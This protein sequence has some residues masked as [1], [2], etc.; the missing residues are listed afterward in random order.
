MNLNRK[1]LA[2]VLLAFAG[3]ARAQTS[4][5]VTGTITASGCVEIDVTGKGVVGISITNSASGS[6]W[7]GTIQPEVAIGGDAPQNTTVTP[8][9]ST[10][11]Q[12][13]ITSNNTYQSF[14][15]SATLFRLCGNTVT[16][17]AVVKLTAS[18]LAARFG[19]G[20]GGGG[21]N[22]P[23]GS[24]GQ[25]QTNAG[26]VFG[27]FTPSGDCTINTTSGV[28]TCTKTNDTAFGTFATQNY[29]TPPTIG[30]TTPAAGF[31]TTGSFTGNLT[32]NMT[33]GPFCV[34]E[35]SGVLSATGADCGSGGG[36][37]GLSG[38]TTGQVPI[39]AT[40]STV[41][42]SKA[43]QGTDT[44]LLSSGTI[45]GTGSNLCTDANGGATTSGCPNGAVT[46]VS[47][48]DTSLTISPTTG[49]IIASINPSFVLPLTNLN[50]SSAGAGQVPCVGSGG[51][52][53]T[54]LAPSIGNFLY[55][56]NSGNCAFSP[57]LSDNGTTLTYTPSGGITASKFTL[58]G[59][60]Y[61]TTVPI[62]GSGTPAAT[63]SGNSGMAVSGDGNFYD[64]VA[65]AGWGQIAAIPGA[66]SGTT[67]AIAANQIIVGSTAGVFKTVTLP[68]CSTSLTWN[69]TSVTA[70]C[71]STTSVQFGNG[72]STAG[73]NGTVSIPSAF[74]NQWTWSGQTGSSYSQ[75]PLALLFPVNNATSPYAAS[76]EGSTSALAWTAPIKQIS[77][78]GWVALNTTYGTN[79]NAGY[80]D[81]EKCESNSTSIFTAGVPDSG[82]N[83]VDGVVLTSGSVF[84]AS[85]TGHVSADQINTAAV[86]ASTGLLGS[87]SSRQL[88]ATTASQVAT[89]VQGLTGCNTA[90][91]VFTPQ[92]SDC[93]A[94]SGGGSLSS[95]TAASASNTL[96]N[97]NNP[98][99]WNWAQ[100]TNSQSAFT[101]GETTAATG[102]GDI[103][104]NVQTLAS[105]TAL[106][107]QITSRGT[108]NG[109]Q[110]TTGGL[111]QAIGSGGI[112]ATECN[113]GTC[114]S[115]TP[116]LSSVTALVSNTTLANGNNTWTMNFANTTNS[117]TAMTFGETSAATGTSDV[118]VAAS[119]LAGSTAVP[120]LV[121]DSLTGSQ[122]LPA[123]K[124]TPVWNT[125]GAVDAGILEN[126]TNTASGAGSLLED[127]Q[128][129]GTSQWKVDKAG[130][131]T[132]LGTGFFGSSAPA[133]TVGT[134]GGSDAAEGTAYT[135]AS[136]TDGWYANATNHCFD[137]IFQTTDEGCVL[138]ASST[139]VSNFTAHQ[140]WGNNT[141]STAAPAAALIGASDT[142]PNFYVAGAGTAQAQTA[143]LTPAVTALTAGVEVRW[144]PTAA[145]TA[146]APTLAV[147]GLTA[148]SITKL[149]TT[150]LVANDL[151]TTAIADAIYDGTEWQLQNPQTAS[152]GGVTSI[153]TTSPITGGTITS[154]GTIA[155]GTCVTSAAS[156]T[157]T[158]LMTGGGSQASQTPD[159][160]ATLSSGGVL[161]GVSLAES[162]LTGSAAQTTITETGTGHEVTRAGVE[163]ANL[164]YPY[165]FTN[166][167]TTTTTSGAL[168]INTT[169]AGGTGQVP[170][171]LNETV[172][173]GDLADFYTLGTFTNGVFSTS[174]ATKEFGFGASGNF[175]AAGSAT[176]GAA[177]CTSFGSAGGLCATEGTSATNVSGTSNLYPDST[178]HEWKAATNGST[179]YGTMVRAQPGA[180]RST[181]LVASVSTATLCAAS[182]GAC[183][184][185]GTYHVH[186]AIYQSGTACTANTT[187]GVLF[188]LTWT[189]GNGT[190]HSAQTVP[191]IAGGSAVNASLTGFA[192]SGTMLWGATTLGAWASGD[193]NIDTNGTIVQ[194]ATTFSQC[195]TGTAT[196]ALSAAVT[197]LQ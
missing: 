161:A 99:V 172:A 100:T 90:N 94:Q 137:V 160:T 96:A 190:A 113:G 130:N 24:A 169:G 71:S 44:N 54:W 55:T 144:L 73:G 62:A 10:T 46:S 192:S 105:S 53:L 183:N 49:A 184:T 136:G 93:V 147:N 121:S 16:N 182:A 14:V 148:K 145:N 30:G 92:A 152:S 77:D 189:D 188:S 109:V 103:E 23:G 4:V 42:S 41:T 111:L 32:T 91:F 194:Y 74:T 106:P 5:P 146:A 83:L 162:L 34:H 129:G 12:A 124:I 67:T 86:P 19:G 21:T 3:M 128:I 15:T 155:C 88:I 75:P 153:A 159:A 50:N 82:T 80:L 165:V 36:G 58:T 33:G 157:S 116:A 31:F 9:G 123:L 52:S 118:E 97:G 180:I 27:A 186:I 174:G 65:N 60:Y 196:Y 20:G 193:L 89:L 149:G 95:L 11:S 68:N 104:F 154:T 25:I 22:N 178:S 170:L 177:N 151:T 85:G 140:F 64:D 66:G 191:I 127:L 87:N 115:S 163:T 164:T 134:A 142:S 112:N 72:F 48:S 143:T 114:A 139:I 195:N 63:G 158:A 156:L 125:T 1:A 8:Y 29:A 138:N 181:G 2:L 61:L 135:G 7:S 35:T 38:M 171:I 81:I 26:S 197:R 101:F 119:T 40:A 166:A 108:A 56:N 187:G 173:A 39:A 6:A 107:I 168:G 133:P 13:T 179:S 59:P 150:A 43:I 131:S 120:L 185:A 126:V 57:N 51:S 47:N 167:N 45:S 78:C 70:G 110:M 117:Q 175:A 98:Q 17:T 84:K 102:T 28:V 79:P 76:Y 132:Q 37:S 176:L 69:N 18:N 122:T 141:G